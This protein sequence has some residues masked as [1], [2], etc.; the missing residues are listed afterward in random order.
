MGSNL[1]NQ[2]GYISLF[3]ITL[4]FILLS[5]NACEKSGMLQGKVIFGSN[6]VP[7]PLPQELKLSTKTVALLNGS[8]SVNLSQFILDGV[9]PYN[10]QILSN[11][12]TSSLTLDSFTPTGVGL[13][14][15]KILDSEERF[16]DFSVKVKG[17]DLNYDFTQGTVS[18]L[19]D[20][21]MNSTLLSHSRND[22]GLN[23]A[24][25]LNGAGNLV[26]VNSGLPRFQYS[27]GVVTPVGLFIE[28]ASTNLIRKTQTITNLNV[29]P[30]GWRIAQS[31]DPALVGIVTTN[32]QNNSAAGPDGLVSATRIRLLATGGTNIVTSLLPATI[33]NSYTASIYI[34]GRVV[35][36]YV[37]LYMNGTNALR[38][39]TMLDTTKYVRYTMTGV[40]TLT[41][42]SFQ[43]DN[44]GIDLNGDLNNQELLDG[45]FWG[46]QIEPGVRASTAIVTNGTPLARG[47]DE[48]KI[49]DLAWLNKKEGTIVL[50]LVVP[51]ILPEDGKYLFGLSNGPLIGTTAADGFY[52]LKSQGKTAFELVKGGTS[53]ISSGSLRPVWRTGDKLK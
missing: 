40:A 7:P 50:S 8:S 49:T 6:I 38:I 12:S 48:L 33:G 41:N 37:T 51:N 31:A 34:K 47:A 25:Y 30:A 32:V 9:P 39:V 11:T 43:V 28:R 4:G 3:C 24:R 35:G 13:V 36:Q 23:I 19:V 2:V 44:D 21:V 10:F 26:A 5:F 42:I 15:F 53:T 16:A 14:Q 45:D 52:I 46:A 22:G 29:D 18:G 27:L 20:G 1:K 17:P